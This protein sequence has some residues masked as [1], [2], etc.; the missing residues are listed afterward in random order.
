MTGTRIDITVKLDEDSNANMMVTVTGEDDYKV[1]IQTYLTDEATLKL[2]SALL[3]T[4]R[5][6]GY[7]VLVVQRLAPGV[8]PIDENQIGTEILWKENH[9]GA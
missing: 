6:K 3:E 9:S 7:S 2:A 5:K 1:T 4:M 8:M